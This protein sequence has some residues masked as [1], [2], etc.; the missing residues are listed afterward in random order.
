MVLAGK[1]IKKLFHKILHVTCVARGHCNIAQVIRLQYNTVV[2][3]LIANVG[4]VSQDKI[5]GSR[6]VEPEYREE[7]QKQGTVDTD[8]Y[9]ASKKGINIR[10]TIE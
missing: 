4:K 2:D 9:W 8:Y 6:K 7:S 3:I 10:I 1:E 5:K